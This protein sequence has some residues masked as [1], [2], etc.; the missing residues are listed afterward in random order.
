MNLKLQYC[1]LYIYIYLQCII[2]STFPDLKQLTC[3]QIHH[4]LLPKLHLLICKTHDGV[5]FN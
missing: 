1:A 5:V 3:V 4:C 2:Y